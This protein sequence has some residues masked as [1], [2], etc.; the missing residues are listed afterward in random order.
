MA[1][2]Y[3]PN[4]YDIGSAAPIDSRFTKQTNAL[5][6]AIPSAVR[7]EGL[8]VYVA[9][10]A[11]NGS[12]PGT[13]YT[14]VGGILDINWAT[15]SLIGGLWYMNGG[16]ITNVGSTDVTIN[17]SLVVPKIKPALD[18]VTAIQLTAF[19]GTTVILNL[20]TTNNRIGIN[21]NAPVYDLDITGSAR[22][23]GTIYASALQGDTL[24]PYTAGS[25]LT[26]STK[27]GAVQDILFKSIG[28]TPTESAR[29][30]TSGRLGLGISVP[31]AKFHTIAN[32]T[33]IYAGDVTNSHISGKGLRVSGASGT[34]QSLEVSDYLGNALFT[35]TPTSIVGTIPISASNLSGTNTGDQT[36]ASGGSIGI[37]FYLDDTSIIG[38]GTQNVNPVNTLSKTPITTAEQVDTIDVPGGT[39]VLD[40]TYL[41]NFALGRT[42]I[43]AGAWTFNIY[44]AT[45]NTGGTSTITNRINKVVVGTG[46]VTTTGT[47]AT[48]TATA[49]TGT[50]FAIANIDTGGTLITDSFLQTTTGL[51]R[52]VSRT[53]DIIVVI[54]T[55][56]TYTNQSAVAYSVHKHLFDI[57]TP[58]ISTTTISLV[59]V[60]TVQ[61]AFTIGITDKFSSMM[62]ASASAHR[63]IT[64]TH[65]GDTHYT[66]F[67]TPLITLHNNLAG[68]QGGASNEYYHLTSAQY[69]AL[70]TSQWI[71]NVNDIYYSAGNVGIGGTPTV[72]YNLDVQGIQRITGKLVSQ[73]AGSAFI[74]LEAKSASGYKWRVY[75]TTNVVNL[76]HINA[77]GYVGINTNAQ[78]DQFG[79]VANTTGIYAGN[80][81]NAHIS[82]K[83]L[84]ISGASGTNPSLLVADYQGAA[85]FTVTPTG[86][87]ATGPISASNL[88]GT[89]TGDAASTPVSAIFYWDAANKK[90]IPYATQTSGAFD[91]STTYPAHFTRLN[92]DGVFYA[93][94][95]AANTFVTGVIGGSESTT[96]NTSY[97]VITAGS[98]PKLSLQPSKADLTGSVAYMFD[99]LNTF[100]V[101][102]TKLLQVKNNTV[103]KFYIDKDG[104]AYANGVHLGATGEPALGNPAV[105]GYVLSSTTLGVRSWIAPGAG[106]SQWTTT[107]S[108]IYFA[109][110]VMIGSTSAPSELLHIKN[111]VSDAAFI[112]L[113]TTLGSGV[114]IGARSD[115]MELY[116]GAAERIRISSAGNVGIGTTAP[117]TKFEVFGSATG[118]AG[119]AW[120][121]SSFC[122]DHINYRGLGFG[123]D[124]A[125]QTGIIISQTNTAPSNIAFWNYSG[126]A[127]R[128]TWRINGVDGKLHGAIG[129]VYAERIG[130][131]SFILNSSGS[132]AGTIQNDAAN[133]WSL[134]VTNDTEVLGTSIL[135]WTSSGN[136]T[137]NNK[138]YFGSNTNPYITTSSNRVILHYDV[139]LYN[140]L[141]FVESDDT[142]LGTGVI[143]ATALQINGATTHNSTV[144]ATNFILS[145]DRTLKTNIQLLDSTRPVTTP[146][147]EFEL[148]TDLG[149]K[150]VGV[151]AQDLE[152]E[153]PEFV[154][155]DDKGIK[156]VAY[157]DLHSKEISDLK[158]QL[159]A[160][161]ERIMELERKLL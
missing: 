77:T 61:P 132:W 143:T 65:N 3:N 134:G 33:T 128:E 44:C 161:M 1:I 35:V 88:S 147:V 122:Q 71:S 157:I 85:L 30:T 118:I 59:S 36:F 53:S 37:G 119:T 104:E 159:K 87:T 52:I 120:Y 148:L 68:L 135:K 49:S 82:G 136:V 86:V 111:S 89:N 142:T 66:N 42:V 54:A 17:T 91:S 110:K 15:S 117:I 69:A 34:N 80:F 95:S 75:D 78:I 47:G 90:Y 73:V 154:R 64:F 32:E 70:G 28:A 99:T 141:N 112:R 31:T 29:L 108:D 140:N 92:Y 6:N 149:Q 144:T 130:N 121:N 83:G 40:E 76:L 38:T 101:A 103:E 72:G 116:A 50:P 151:I 115:H 18:S 22:A 109:N 51:F 98:N 81:T 96:I 138:L 152:I 45:N 12:I 26:I 21:N 46:T 39:T 145:S 24:V 79:V 124:T 113:E 84:Y 55:P 25:F 14:L 4:T 100:T 16:T 19:N 8:T 160:M 129:C 27:P 9:D 62:L 137:I 125:S 11:G 146:Y 123:Y 105:N 139:S 67:Q 60:Q 102:G 107:G 58:D 43:D 114:Y 74:E 126:S 20:D 133:T 153:H 5:R 7:Y 131:N 155:T 97:I 158:Y 63:T 2:Y 156:S 41:Y 93:N 106:S 94:T 56:T 48:R 10:P 57:T 127:W 150:R 23:T 13:T